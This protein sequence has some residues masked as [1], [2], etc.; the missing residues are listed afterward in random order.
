MEFFGYSNGY[1]NEN[2]PTKMID[3]FFA[4]NNNM[5]SRKKATAVKKMVAFA[6]NLNAHK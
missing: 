2:E 4:N 1:E 5:G 3:S 6:I